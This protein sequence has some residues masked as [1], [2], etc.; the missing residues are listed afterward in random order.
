M[1]RRCISTVYAIHT[2]RPTRRTSANT[3][4]AMRTVGRNDRDAAQLAE[5][6]TRPRLL[7]RS[8]DQEVFVLEGQHFYSAYRVDDV[9]FDGPR[10]ELHMIVLVDGGGRVAIYD[11]AAIPRQLVQCE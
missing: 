7:P 3:Q 5:A 2:P 4:T 8:L 11:D 9:R 1:G 10:H 6:R